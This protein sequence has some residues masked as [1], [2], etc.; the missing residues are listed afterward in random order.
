MVDLSRMLEPAAGFA[1]SENQLFFRLSY[2]ISN[3]KSLTFEMMVNVQTCTNAQL[4]DYSG[5]TT[6]KYESN[7]VSPKSNNIPRV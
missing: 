1:R 3:M 6:T 7:R 4:N 5:K 2:T